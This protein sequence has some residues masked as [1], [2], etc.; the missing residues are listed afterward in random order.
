MTVD[1]T[2]PRIPVPTVGL[3]MDDLRRA[4]ARHHPDQDYVC[5]SDKEDWPCN[6]VLL[7][8]LILHL[9]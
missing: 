6:K 5:V 2:D 8:E 7:I 9:R 4:Y 1:T 3:S